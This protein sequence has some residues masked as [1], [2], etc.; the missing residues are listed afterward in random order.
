[1]QIISSMRLWPLRIVAAKPA[2][3]GILHRLLDGQREAVADLA[4]FTRCSSIA[5]GIE[6]KARNNPTLR[7][8]RP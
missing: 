8:K 2:V 1:M 3:L 4:A 7:Q 6:P 5:T